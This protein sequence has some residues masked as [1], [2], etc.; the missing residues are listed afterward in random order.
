MRHQLWIPQTLTNTIRLFALDKPKKVGQRIQ[1]DPVRLYHIGLID[2]FLGGLYDG[3]MS[4]ATLKQHG[5]FGLGAPD[6]LDGELTILHGRVYQTQASGH[7]FEPNDSAS[8]AYAFVHPFKADTTIVLPGSTDKHQ[9]EQALDRLLPTVNGLYAIRLTGQFKRLKTRAF[10][11]V[12]QKPYAALA[13]MLPRQ[14]VFE[15][16]SI[17]GDV[18]GYRL[19][20]F[21]NGV[22]IPGYHFHFLSLDRAKGGHVLDMETERIVVQVDSLAGYTVDVPKTFDYQRFNFN[23]DRRA[24][25]KQ[26]ERG[27]N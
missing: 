1:A 2:G 3:V 6:H 15:Y 23:L 5:D 20:A 21:V 13:T 10:P 24:D 27:K 16:E 26:V 19:P 11:S 22:N 17:A 14:H 9:L 18:I 25:I 4:Y 8:T 12:S 7:T